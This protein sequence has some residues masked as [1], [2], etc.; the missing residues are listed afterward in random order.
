MSALQEPKIAL[1]ASL[2][3]VPSQE[4]A[5]CRLAKATRELQ[6]RWGI[7]T[8]SPVH[9]IHTVCDC[10]A[11]CSDEHLQSRTP[12]EVVLFGSDFLAIPY[13]LQCE[14]MGHD[15]CA[16]RPLILKA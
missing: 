13:N 9:V 14:L 6:S 3:S 5:E 1:Y 12:K 7:A 11:A 10:L 2:A 15:L 8:L 4:K 16:S